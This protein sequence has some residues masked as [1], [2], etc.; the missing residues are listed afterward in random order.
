[1]PVGV[2]IGVQGTSAPRPPCSVSE[3]ELKLSPLLLSGSL[4][5]FFSFRPPLGLLGTISDE[6]D[7]VGDGHGG[8]CG[9]V[10]V[11][12]DE[13]GCRKLLET[14]LLTGFVSHS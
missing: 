12:T 13:G 6:L 10:G 1:M 11:W 5:V 2:T 9:V 14:G 7:G 8:E 4:L 3:S